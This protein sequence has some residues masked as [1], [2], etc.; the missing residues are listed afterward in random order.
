MLLK[1][2]EGWILQ[3]S[4]DTSLWAQKLLLPPMSYSKIDV[5]KLR[6]NDF[7]GFLAVMITT[8]IVIRP[9]GGLT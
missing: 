3:F 9:G 2:S 5:L 6:S 8:K 7:L 1:E 4:R